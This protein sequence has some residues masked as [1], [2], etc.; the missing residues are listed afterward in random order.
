VSVAWRED[1]RLGPAAAAFLA[2][3]RQE[4]AA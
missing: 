2:L 4:R 1:R 3:A